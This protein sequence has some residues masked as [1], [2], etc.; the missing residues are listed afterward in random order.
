[1]DGEETSK[2]SAESMEHLRVEFSFS[3]CVFGVYLCVCC[4]KGKKKSLGCS[5]LGLHGKK[6]SE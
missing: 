3:L 1:M 2:C 5:L 6:G 4:G